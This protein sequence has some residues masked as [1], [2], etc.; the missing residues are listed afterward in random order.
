MKISRNCFSKVTNLLIIKQYEK[1]EG[2]FWMF[3]SCSTVH[4][5]V[6]LCLFVRTRNFFSG[7]AMT[8]P[9]GSSRSITCKTTRKDE[10]MTDG[11]PVLKW[12]IYFTYKRAARNGNSLR[13]L[14]W[15]RSW[16]NVLF[17]RLQLYYIILKM[18]R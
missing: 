7:C 14:R 2:T 12:Y 15:R 11:P 4:S 3:P 9:I 16:G 1:Q 5:R 6:K 8:Y 13:L 17:K 18:A 10:A